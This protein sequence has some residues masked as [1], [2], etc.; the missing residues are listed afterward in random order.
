MPAG[1]PYHYNVKLSQQPLAEKRL[2][3]R[4]H[5]KSVLNRI[6]PDQTFRNLVG[7]KRIDPE[8]RLLDGSN[9]T[10]IRSAEDALNN[11]LLV[12]PLLSPAQCHALSMAFQELEIRPSSADNQRPF[13]DIAATRPEAGRL[14]L[15]T[16]DRALQRVTAFFRLKAPIRQGPLQFVRRDVGAFMQPDVGNAPRT[17]GRDSSGGGLLGILYLNDDY[18]GGELYFTARNSVIKPQAG[19]FVAMS[20]GFHHEHAVLRIQHGT[21]LTMHFSLTFDPQS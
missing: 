16:R 9:V 13:A 14:M 18:E 6:N 3:P 8:G 20:A 5:R 21:G 7:R 1:L 2:D 12:T 11:E 15:E 10:T 19:L 17:G 4:W